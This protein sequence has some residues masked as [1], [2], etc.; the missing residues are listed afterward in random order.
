MIKDFDAQTKDKAGGQTRVLLMDGHSSHYTLELLEY[1]R[2]HG[3]VI[4][5]Y[6]P[7]CTHAL[8]GLDVVCFAKMKNEFNQE[9]NKFEDLHKTRV[10]KADFAGVFGQA[11]LQAFTEDTIKAAFAA[12]GVAEAE[13]THINEGDIPSAPTKPRACRYCSNGNLPAYSIRDITI[14]SHCTDCRPFTTYPSD[15]IHSIHPKTS[16]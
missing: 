7:H 12:T 13:L 10:T 16:P 11:F 6:P 9:I 8:Q 14:N 5:G 4:L 15:A 2:T 3:I 1:A